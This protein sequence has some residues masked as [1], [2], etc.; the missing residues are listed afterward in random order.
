MKSSVHMFCEIC[1]FELA[2]YRC[3]LCG[4]IVCAQDYD[5]DKNICLVCRDTLCNFCGS[6]L[7]IKYCRICGRVGCD[8]CLIQES[9]VSYVCKECI[10]SIKKNGVGDGVE[11]R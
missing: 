4:R 9:L 5:F 6:K 8:D 2:M 3:G 11:N 10:R 7:S 1:D